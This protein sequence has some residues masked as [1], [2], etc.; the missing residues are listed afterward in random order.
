MII[1]LKTT[2]HRAVFFTAVSNRS[3]LGALNNNFRKNAKGTLALG[4]YLKLLKN[5]AISNDSLL[6][7]INT[8]EY[9][10]PHTDIE[11]EFIL[12]MDDYP[13]THQSPTK[14]LTI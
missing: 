4:L 10:K 1:V 7:P 9:T 11:L 3:N 6:L 12:I 14:L 5:K 13:A 2:I 8:R